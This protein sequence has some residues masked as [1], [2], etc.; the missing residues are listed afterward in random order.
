MLLFSV[1]GALGS[2]LILIINFA[3]LLTFIMGTYCDYFTTPKFVIA[4]T[5]LFFALFISFPES[6][7]FLMK[8]NKVEVNGFGEEL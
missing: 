8:Q 7:L 5:V 6:P 2:I 4:L 1:R 3:I